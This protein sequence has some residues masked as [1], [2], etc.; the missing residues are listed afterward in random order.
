MKAM[1]S[2]NLSAAPLIRGV[3]DGLVK[4]ERL[5]SLRVMEMSG[6][7][8][9]EFSCSTLVLRVSFWLDGMAGGFQRQMVNLVGLEMRGNAVCEVEYWIAW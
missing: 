5:L 3:G 7:G 4:K 2:T 8:R 1:R 9:I 6:F